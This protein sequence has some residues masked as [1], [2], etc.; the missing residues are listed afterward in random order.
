MV[1]ALGG[2][3][4]RMVLE[5]SLINLSKRMN[6]KQEKAPFSRFSLF[7]FPLSKRDSSPRFSILE[8]PPP[9]PPFLFKTPQSEVKRLKWTIFS[10]S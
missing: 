6:R 8:R 5:A 10:G 9:P 7:L 1:R 2:V 3:Y 4:R